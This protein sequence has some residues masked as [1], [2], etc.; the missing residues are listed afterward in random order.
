[1]TD[2]KVV[3]FQVHHLDVMDLREIELGGPFRLGD[4]KDRIDSIAKESVQAATF[5]YDGRVLLCAGFTLLWPGVY[6]V[7]MIPSTHI[8]KAPISVARMIRRYVDR[9][10][11]D[12]K[13]HR[14]QTTT[15]DDPLHRRWMEFL[16]FKLEGVMERYTHDGKDML[17]YA[18]T[19]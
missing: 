18:R 8:Q 11:S 4:F 6:V 16:G 15:H 9:I 19:A 14:I 2:V 10:M 13:A 3:Q 17:M 1:M 12:F 7:W 5:L